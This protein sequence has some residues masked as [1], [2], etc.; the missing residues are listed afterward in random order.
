MDNLE[1]AI[2]LLVEQCDGARS[3]DNVGFNKLDAAFGHYL[4]KLPYSQWTDAQKK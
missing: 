2:K 3:Q 1:K 4:A